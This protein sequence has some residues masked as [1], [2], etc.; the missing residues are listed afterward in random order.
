MMVFLMKGP[1]KQDMSER[2][3]KASNESFENF[4]ELVTRFPRANTRLMPEIVWHIC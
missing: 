2:D 4:K 1:L 3:S